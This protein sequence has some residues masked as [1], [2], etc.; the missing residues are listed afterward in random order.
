[1]MSRTDRLAEWHRASHFLGWLELQSGPTRSLAR[2]QELRA[3]AHSIE[4]N[5]GGAAFLH[6]LM[7]S[8]GLDAEGEQRAAGVWRKEN[9]ASGPRGPPVADRFDVYPSGPRA[10][11]MNL[12]DLLFRYFG[13]SEM[14]HV[15]PAAQLAGL[16]RMQVDFGLEEDRGNRFALWCLLHMLGAAPDLDVAFEQDGDREAARNFKDLLAGAREG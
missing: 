16:E 7:E 15:P 9:I 10:D 6:A 14:T 8:S 2:E 4:R 11:H 3:C 1:M 13:T 12:D 5:Y